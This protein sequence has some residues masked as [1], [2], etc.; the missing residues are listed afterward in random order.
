MIF[1]LLLTLGLGIFSLISY[2]NF[3]A[4]LL[5]FFAILPSYLLRFSIGPLPTTFLEMSFFI[6]LALWVGNHRATTLPQILRSRSFLI[7]LGVLFVISLVSLGVVP[8]EH[9]F[10]SLGLWRAY[11]LEPFIFGWVVRS[12][13]RTEE[14]RVRTFFSL[15]F[16]GLFLAGVGILQYITQKGIPAPWDI[17]RRITSVFDYPNALGLFLAPL[18]SALFV[19]SVRTWNMQSLKKKIFLALSGLFIF[20]AIILAK[21]EAALVAIPGALFCIFLLTPQQTK[22]QKITAGM[23]AAFCVCLALSFSPI[24]EK[25]F[26]QDLSGQV[27]LSQWKETALLLYDHP[28]SGAGFGYYPVLLRSYHTAWQYEIF[29]YPHTL[30]MNIWVE[31]GILGVVVSIFGLVFLGASVWK[32]RNDPFVLAASAALLTMCI[33]GL[34]DVPFF[35]NDLAMLTVLFILL[36]LPK[37]KSSV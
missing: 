27:R 1:F 37:Q 35:K 32:Q 18:F 21:T 31:T 14:M 19:F 3:S 17:E 26:L 36:I 13:L 9:L 22:K 30:I 10:A 5:L 24:R 4:G 2:K 29:Q 23:C 7:S 6:L 20:L 34:V 33:H 12:E 11:L 8:R 28:F 25:L 16:S 15:F